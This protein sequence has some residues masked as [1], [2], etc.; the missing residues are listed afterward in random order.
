MGLPDI[1]MV[2][3]VVTAALLFALYGLL[4]KP[5]QG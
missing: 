3:L 2:M 5:S 4:L 1:A